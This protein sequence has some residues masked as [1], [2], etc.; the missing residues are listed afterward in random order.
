[1]WSEF[2]FKIQVEI[3]FILAEVVETLL[4]QKDLREVCAALF[5]LAKDIQEFLMK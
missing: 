3:Y 1:L 5:T 4:V 2:T